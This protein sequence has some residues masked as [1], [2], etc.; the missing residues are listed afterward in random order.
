M[1]CKTCRK[2]VYAH[3]AGTNHGLNLVLTLLTFGLWLPIWAWA[4]ATQNYHVCG[5]CGRPIL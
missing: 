1:Y 2:H 3:P 4:A 5:S